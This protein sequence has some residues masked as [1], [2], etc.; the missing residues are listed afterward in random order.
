MN[1][2]AK[3]NCRTSHPEEYWSAGKI[4]NVPNDIGE[5]LLQNKNFVKVSETKPEAESEEKKNE[6]RIRKKRSIRN[7]T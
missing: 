6:F 7:R 4:V 3:I 1:I 5:K 2:K